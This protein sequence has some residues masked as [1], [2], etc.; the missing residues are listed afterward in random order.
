MWSFLACMR[1]TYMCRYRSRTVWTPP[2]WI[3]AW[4]SRSTATSG[5][6]AS[7]FPVRL[8][9]LLLL[10]IIIQLSYFVVVVCVVLTSHLMSIA[11]F[12]LWVH[13][14]YYESL[15][16]KTL[17][18][19]SFLSIKWSLLLKIIGVKK[20]GRKIDSNKEKRRII[21]CVYICT[22]RKFN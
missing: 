11:V 8:V 19:R 18:S 1:Y 7:R 20:L 15:S 21:N 17:F 14:Q 5:F 6:T 3:A 12:S 16:F 13:C 22:Y 10:L 9:S 2:S 4:P